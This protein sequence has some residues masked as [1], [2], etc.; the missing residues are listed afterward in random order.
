M[1][2]EDVQARAVAEDYLHGRLTAD[3][4]EAYERHFFECDRCFS[5]LEALRATAAALRQPPTVASVR[6][7]NA[8]WL[9][10]AAVLVLAVASAVL[11]VRGRS[12]REGPSSATDATARTPAAQPAPPAAPVDTLARLA[13]F[14]PPAYLPP[15][16][17]SETRAGDFEKGMDRYVQRDYAGAIPLLQSTVAREPAHDSA[18]FYLGVCFLLTGNTDEGVRTLEI[19]GADPQNAMAEEAR[20]FSAHGYLQRGEADKAIAALDRVIALEGDREKEA[21]ALRAAIEQ[22]RTRR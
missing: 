11:L 10:L 9:A 5:E 3:D 6:V 4:Q 22:S 7:M 18:R 8:R 20:F 14:D 1:T 21:R 15:R 16:L 13:R 19:L 2:C 17:R 12:D